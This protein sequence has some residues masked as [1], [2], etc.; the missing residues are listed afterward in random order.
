MQC[1]DK[2]IKEQC[3]D[4]GSSQGIPWIQIGKL[5][6]IHENGN[7]LGDLLAINIENWDLSVAEAARSLICLCS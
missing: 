4:L 5:S 1:E 6:C 2:K 3:E 7:A